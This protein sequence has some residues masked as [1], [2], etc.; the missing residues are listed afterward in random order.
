MANFPFGSGSLLGG[1]PY[2]NKQPRLDIYED[3]NK[4][5]RFKIFM[6]SDEVAASTQGYATKS[7]CI[8][9]LK[10]IASH[11]IELERTGKLV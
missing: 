3:D 5:W 9:N 10:K 7:L 8:D 4:K 6:S 2:I 1:N 11:I